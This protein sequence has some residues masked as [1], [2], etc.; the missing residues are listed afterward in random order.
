MTVTPPSR[1]PAAGLSARCVCCRVA[2]HEGRRGLQ[3]AAGEAEGLLKRPF[4][5][6]A[7]VAPAASHERDIAA[8]EAVDR[9]PVVADEEAGDARARECFKQRHSA[10]GDVLE[11]VD[12][13]MAVGRRP[14]GLADVRRG[15]V[16]QVVEVPLPSQEPLVARPD[17]LEHVEERLAAL[18]SARVARTSA[19]QVGREAVGLDVVEEGGHQPRQPRGRP[20][21]EALEERLH[22]HGIER[23]ARLLELRAQG[24]LEHALAPLPAVCLDQPRAALLVDAALPRGALGVAPP[25]RRRP[26]Q[27]VQREMLDVYAV[28]REVEVRPILAVLRRRGVDLVGRLVPEVDAV[29]REEVR[30]L[31]LLE[32]TD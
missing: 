26:S 14:A 11:L 21:A 4:T 15:L 12:Q 6:A 2:R 20:A 5:N 18:A 24:L 25:P 30:D 31:E 17:L 13:H 1:M 7:E 28:V 29:E 32:A 8:R 10:C 22:W 19:Q 27:P 16:D 3:D 23:H 9:L